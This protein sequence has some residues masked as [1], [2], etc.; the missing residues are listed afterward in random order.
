M[1]FFVVPIIGAEE[2]FGRLYPLPGHGKLRLEV[3]I[4]WIHKIKQPPNRLPPTIE[5]KNKIKDS[6]TILITTIWPANETI[7]PPSDKSIQQQVKKAAEAVGNQ[8]VEKTLP[9]KE[10]KGTSGFG[11][12]YFATDPSPKPGEYKYM[13]QGII[14]IGELSVPFTIL[15]NDENENI[16]NDA[17]EMLK[18]AKHLKNAT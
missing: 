11:Y 15:T 2:T 12:Y 18:S 5:F 10:I 13:T 17:L 16:I 3:P 1:M 14:R 4:S 9:I 8:S 6:F 7:P